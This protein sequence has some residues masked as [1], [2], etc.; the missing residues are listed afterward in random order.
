MSK[1]TP[2]TEANSL[3]TFC[4]PDFSKC[5]PAAGD[6]V[7]HLQEGLEHFTSMKWISTEDSGS[8]QFQQNPVFNIVK[9]PMLTLG[10]CCVPFCFIPTSARTFEK[11]LDGKSCETICLSNC[12]LNC[13]CCCGT[14]WMLKVNITVCY[15]LNTP[16][17]NTKSNRQ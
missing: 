7:P 11:V 3:A 14:C 4:I 17:Q 1:D 5:G 10:V 9:N 2:A 13:C 15:M 6:L 8:K 16:N 12:L